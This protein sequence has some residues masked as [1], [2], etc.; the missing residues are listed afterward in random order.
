[1]SWRAGCRCTPHRTHTLPHFRQ[2]N[3]S[4][5]HT[6]PQSCDLVSML[7]SARPAPAVPGTSGG[8]SVVNGP[9]TCDPPL[10]VVAQLG[11]VDMGECLLANGADVN[12]LSAITGDTPLH[13]AI[14]YGRSDFI[15]LLHAHA[16]EWHR[17]SRGGVAPFVLASITQSAAA[18]EC[19]ADAG[20]ASPAE[21]SSLDLLRVMLAFP[22]V[23]T[24]TAAACR[25]LLSLWEQGAGQRG[26]A[27]SL[28]LQWFGLL[29]VSS[30]DAGSPNPIVNVLSA[31]L[32]AIC[33]RSS[34][35]FPPLAASPV[36]PRNA[37]R[38]A[39]SLS[40][41][42]F[43]LKCGTCATPPPPA[44]R[45][46][47]ASSCLSCSSCCQRPSTPPPPLLL[48]PPPHCN[49]CLSAPP[50]QQSFRAHRSRRQQQLRRLLRSCCRP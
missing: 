8:G 48:P 12:L 19:C 33:R 25:M 4:T 2:R 15:R 39:D 45:R 10:H 38:A 9:F 49:Q 40:A 17:P 18:L 43:A 34:R 21:I 6:T 32:I 5:P 37:N 44:S 46:A 11:C 50:Q 42:V 7:A 1:M 27:D 31:T 24:V 29:L 28:Q 30:A 22:S 41:A 23:D 36:A 14:C 13:R 20:V 26:V 47:P 3:P 35:S 16:A